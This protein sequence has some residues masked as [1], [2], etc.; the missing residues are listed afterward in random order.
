MA[1]SSALHIPDQ[2]FFHQEACIQAISRSYTPSTSRWFICIGRLSISAKGSLTGCRNELAAA[3]GCNI[4]RDPREE[5]GE[6][7]F[8]SGISW[9]AS[10]GRAGGRQGG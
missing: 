1:I 8:V 5:A 10:G 4:Y 2:P 9:A 6:G 7:L 3:D